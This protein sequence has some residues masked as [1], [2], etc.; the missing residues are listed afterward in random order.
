MI[1]NYSKIPRLESR[2]LFEYRIGPNHKM[3]SLVVIFIMC[4][5]CGCFELIFNVCVNNNDY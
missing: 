3:I 2:I 5:N 1:C 4:G